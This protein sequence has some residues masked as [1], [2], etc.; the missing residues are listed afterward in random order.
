[1]QVAGSLACAKR[2][3]VNVD[4]TKIECELCG[5]QLDFALPSASSVEGEAISITIMVFSFF[6]L[7]ELLVPLGFDPILLCM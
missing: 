6:L 7:C 5:A 3:W 4:V 1:M 2:G